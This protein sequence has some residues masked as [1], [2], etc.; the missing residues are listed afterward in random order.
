ME[1]PDITVIVDEIVIIPEHLVGQAIMIGYHPKEHD[2]KDAEPFLGGDLLQ[3][4]IH[5]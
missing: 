4:S 1:I 3:R 2:Q 5:Q